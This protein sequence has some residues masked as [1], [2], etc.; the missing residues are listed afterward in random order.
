M[1]NFVK[2]KFTRNTYSILS[3]LLFEKIADFGKI[4]SQNQMILTVPVSSEDGKETVSITDTL[5]EMSTYSFAMSRLT[6]ILHSLEVANDE[7]KKVISIKANMTFKIDMQTVI[8]LRE[9]MTELIMEQT[10]LI[11]DY[12]FKLNT[13]VSL[14]K[15]VDNVTSIQ[16]I[17]VI[18]QASILVSEYSDILSRFENGIMD[19]A[20][21]LSSDSVSTLN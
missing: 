11:N 18:R 9:F 5:K 2:I 20:S 13:F 1:E 16:A 17:D 3:Q 21:Q 6:T 4:I 7:F 10:Q 14:G 19:Y 8:M 15:I 12:S